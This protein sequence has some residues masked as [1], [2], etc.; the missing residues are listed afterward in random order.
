MKINLENKNV[1]ITATGV[2]S[3]GSGTCE[4]LSACGTN[5]IINDLNHRKVNEA[6]VKYR[7]AISVIG[8]VSD[9]KDGEIKFYEISKNIECFMDL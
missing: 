5:Q 1:L 8:D 3:E 7:N 9:K 4:A 6:V 2:T